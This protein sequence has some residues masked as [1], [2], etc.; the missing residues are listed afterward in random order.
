MGDKANWALLTYGNTPASQG[1][2]SAVRGVPSPDLLRWISVSA[3][4][5]GAHHYPAGKSAASIASGNQK[6]IRNFPV[7]RLDIFL[8]G[9]ILF[10]SF[11]EPPL[12]P[13]P[14][15]PSP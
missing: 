10:C 9:N 8:Y 4:S 2:G 13:T 11:R 7:F 6:M 1:S 3:S 15:M 14:S 5:S 12:P